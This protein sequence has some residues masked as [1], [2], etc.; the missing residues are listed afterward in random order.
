MEHFTVNHVRK[1]HIKCYPDNKTISCKRG[2]NVKGNAYGRLSINSTA[3]Y[4]HRWEFEITRC[5]LILLGIIQ[6][7]KVKDTKDTESFKSKGYGYALGNNG[8]LY[9]PNGN[10]NELYYLR[11]SDKTFKSGDVVSMELDLITKRLTLMI[12][13][14]KGIYFADI[15]T[16]PYIQ[17]RMA[18]RL[19]SGHNDNILALWS[20]YTDEEKKRP[21]GEANEAPSDLPKEVQNKSQSPYH[22]SF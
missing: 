4:I 12:N 9:S 15:E 11:T 8:K 5:S 10:K 7:D 19:N 20:Y 2:W 17:Y 14:K 3:Q 16:G 18:V 6:S 1:S 13:Q 21:E 22:V